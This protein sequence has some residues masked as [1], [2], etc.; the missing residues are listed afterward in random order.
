LV[1]ARFEIQKMAQVTVVTR[2]MQ[3]R[4]LTPHVLLDAA[5][6]SDAEAASDAADM[7]TG[8]FSS[9]QAIIRDCYDAFLDGLERFGG[10]LETELASVAEMRPYIGYWIDDIA[11]ATANAYDAAWC[12]CLLAYIGGADGETDW[13]P[14][15]VRRFRML[16]CR[17]C[18]LWSQPSRSPT[19]TQSTPFVRDGSLGK[20]TLRPTRSGADHVYPLATGVDHEDRETSQALNVQTPLVKKWAATT[21]GQVHEETCAKPSA[22]PA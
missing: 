16:S 10:Y 21:G 6:G 5:S 17:R 1:C 15:T 14:L 20:W 13:R 7:Q 3:C 4:A 19:R 22:A 2:P 8:K 9:E 18:D 12:A 11:A